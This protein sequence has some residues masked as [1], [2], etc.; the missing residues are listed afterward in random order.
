MQRTTIAAIPLVLAALLACKKEEAPPAPVA[1]ATVPSPA[2]TPA[3]AATQ[4][5]A[6]VKDESPIP[7]IPEGR[8]KPPT[9]A[10]WNAATNI[11]TQEANSQP[12]ICRPTP[13]SLRA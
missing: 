7:D 11:N 9:V 3:P 12:D 1:V 5:P 2:E 4:E 6:P 8:S 10:E 13:A